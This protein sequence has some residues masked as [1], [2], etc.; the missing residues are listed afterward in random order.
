M[1]LICLLALVQQHMQSIS[2]KL[3]FVLRV[4]L[5]PCANYACV[6]FCSSM[7]LCI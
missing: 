5:N 2:I 7:N 4:V 3:G 1:V 6:G